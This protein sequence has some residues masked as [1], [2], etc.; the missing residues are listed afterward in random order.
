[1]LCNP[2]W[3]AGPYVME[4]L[5]SFYLTLVWAVC[6][7]PLLRFHFHTSR[8]RDTDIKSGTKPAAKELTG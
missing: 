4:L 8:A 1:M 5:L 6:M 2:V 3:L 7:Y